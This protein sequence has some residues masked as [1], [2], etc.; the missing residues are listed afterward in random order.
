MAKQERIILADPDIHGRTNV[1]AMLSRADFLVIGEAEDGITALKMIRDRQPDLV[2]ADTALPGLNGFELAGIVHDDHL[3]PVIVMS[4]L[5]GRD[6]PARL[7]EVRASG[8]L[9]KPVEITSLLSVVEVA[10]THYEEV[11][12]LERQVAKLKDELETRK[13]VERAKGVLMSSLG[14]SEAEAFRRI[15]KQ[16]MNRR[17]SMR[18]VAEAIILAHNV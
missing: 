18:A 1:K 13:V 2:L 12:E 7:R 10:L 9:E 16:S 14:L 6:L 17:L 11:M 8:F 5:F 4:N 15:Q 3:A